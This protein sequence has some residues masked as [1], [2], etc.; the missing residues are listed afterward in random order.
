MSYNLIAVMVTLMYTLSIVTNLKCMNKKQV[1][2]LLKMQQCKLL[3]VK[4]P[5]IALIESIQQSSYIKVPI[6]FLAASLRYCLQTIKISHCKYLVKWLLV[7]YSVCN[8]HHISVKNTQ[9]TSKSFLVPLA[10]S[11]PSPN[12]SLRQP[13]TTL[14]L[15]TFSITLYK[16]NFI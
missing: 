1:K 14:H 16:W 8:H 11:I 5:Q 3:N 2:M 4:M 10:Q 6:P 7:N 15:C 9:I 13:P 12:L